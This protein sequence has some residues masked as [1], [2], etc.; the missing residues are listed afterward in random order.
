MAFIVFCLMS[1][2]KRQKSNI[3][4]AKCVK[5]GVKI[6]EILWCFENKQILKSLGKP[7]R[8]ISRQAVTAF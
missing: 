2:L 7:S 4:P 3:K 8:L 6:K 5:F 1:Q